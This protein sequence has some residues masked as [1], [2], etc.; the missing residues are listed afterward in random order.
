MSNADRPNET[1]ETAEEISEQVLSL[2]ETETDDVE[3]HSAALGST[4]SLAAC[5]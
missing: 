3:A 1:P 4:V 2:Q 5:A